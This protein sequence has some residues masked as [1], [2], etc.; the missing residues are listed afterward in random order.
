[1]TVPTSIA[2]TVG[3]TLIAELEVDI[4]QQQVTAQPV[5]FKP[6]NSSTAISDDVAQKL[7]YPRY[8][9]F[10]AYANTMLAG[11]LV[12]KVYSHE[13]SANHRPRKMIYVH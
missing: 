9:T 7:S 1:M 8:F 10:L 12:G 11:F 6:P 4:Q 13:G 3:A 2:A 5:V